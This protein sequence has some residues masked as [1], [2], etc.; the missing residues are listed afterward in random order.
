[1]INCLSKPSLIRSRIPTIHRSF[2]ESSRVYIQQCIVNSTKFSILLM[3]VQ[4]VS[5]ARAV[6]KHFDGSLGV[7][8]PEKAYGGSCLLF[9]PNATDPWH[10]LWV[11]ITTRSYQVQKKYPFCLYSK[12]SVIR[13][14]VIRKFQ[15][16]NFPIFL[17]LSTCS[18]LYRNT[19]LL[20]YFC[21]YRFLNVLISNEMNNYMT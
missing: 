3:G 8:L 9:D 11:D 20:W 2:V 10:N 16:R 5:D 21:Q 13:N 14:L 19:K 15:L 12:N 4:N 17:I 6:M 18:S 7:R 1:M